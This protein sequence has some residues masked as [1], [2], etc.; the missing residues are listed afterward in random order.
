MPSFTTAVALL[1]VLHAGHALPT[2]ISPRAS[3]TDLGTTQI[4]SFKPYT[5]YASAGYCEPAETL[6]WNCGA[7]CEANPSF[8]PTASGGDGTVE[9]FCEYCQPHICARCTDQPTQGMWD[10]T[11]RWTPSLSHIRAHTRKL[12]TFSDYTS[13]FHRSCSPLQVASHRRRRYC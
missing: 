11:R 7:N 5:F 6:A 13:Y 4:A 12:C 9:Q 2:S 1:A 3:I 8:V 10:T